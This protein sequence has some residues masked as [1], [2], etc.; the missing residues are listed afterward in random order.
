MNRREFLIQ[1]TAAAASA[2]LAA[3]TLQAQKSPAVPFKISLAQ[4]SL[5]R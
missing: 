3:R 4:W 1:S 5:H 2:A